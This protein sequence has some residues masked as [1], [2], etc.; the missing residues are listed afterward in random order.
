MSIFHDLGLGTNQKALKLN[1]DKQIYG[2]F[3]E[4]GA[5]QDVAG[6][7]F[8][9]GGA[10]GTVAKSMSAYDMTFS[11]AIYGTISDKRYVCEER[12]MSMLNHEYNLLIERLDEQRGSETTFFSF[13][14][15]VVALNYH[16]TNQPHGWIGCRFQIEPQGEFHDVIVHVKMLDNDTLL[17]QHA[18][19]IIGVNLIYGCFY[20]HENPEIL[21][22]S[23]RDN[24]S[25]GR[26]QIDMIRF[27]GP[28]F[29]NVDGRL[30][31]L[32]LVKNGFCDLA[33]FGPDG[34]ILQPSDTLYKKHIFV[35]RGRFRPII[36]VHIDML[37]NGV[38]QF[39]Q[40]PDVDE[41]K[42]IV[43]SELTLHSLKEGQ[44][45]IDDKDFL[46]RVDILCSL[47]QT[48]M[49]TNYVEYYK[50]VADL[51]KITRLKIGLVIG[52]PNL[53]YIFQEDNYKDLKGEILEGFATLFSQ[54]VK[55]FVYPTLRNSI[56][57]NC[58]RFNPPTHLFDLFRYLIANN[59][60]EDIFHY[61]QANLNIQT[62][63]MLDLIQKGEVGWE[64]NV[65]AEVVKM[66]KDRCLFG[67]PCVVIPKKSKN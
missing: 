49:I 55:L 54:K 6:A 40:E 26:I 44:Q 53:E 48:V 16:K 22:E 58:M 47:G 23:L 12:L 39:I 59:K 33:L 56:I 37:E 32:R 1:L 21:L 28:K 57:M 18:I 24:L 42:L 5:G 60:I 27:E 45:E 52:Y 51:S 13:A 61:N 43:L 30:M 62:D 31:S 67:F 3:A 19:G 66:I 4:I 8:K 65:P 46:D 36:N 34:K 29:K 25:L 35:L 14:N 41:S 64:E 17:Q 63:N 50:L 2:T 20:Y 9:A 11:D 10:S 15:T 38:R 7:F